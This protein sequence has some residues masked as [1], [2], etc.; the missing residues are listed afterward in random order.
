MRPFV[1]F[2]LLGCL[3][4]LGLT[5]AVAVG[6]A[7]RA[8]HG[9]RCQ[10]TTATTTQP[11]STSTTTTP[12]TTTTPTTGYPASFYSGPAG[13]NILLPPNGTYPADG[14][15]IGEESGNGLTQLQSREQ[16]IGRSFN[17]YSYYAQHR[18]DP[19]PTILGQVVAAG[20]IPMLSWWPTPEHADQIISGQAD[21]CIKAFGDAIANQPA[22]VLVRMYHE[23]NG[24][25]MPF[26]MNSDGTRATASE[27]KQM[28][29][30]TVDVLRTTGFFSRASVVWNVSEG[31]YDNGDAWN[32][33]TPYPGDSYLD[34]VSSDGY[35]GYINGGWCGDHDTHPP[36]TWCP[37][38]D[39]FTHGNH[40]PAYT[41]RGVE[42]D[43]RGR[44]PYM[45]AET[46]S[47]EDPNTPGRKG[48]W[49][50]DMGN[51]AKTY[52][53]GLYAIVYFDLSYNGADWNLDTSTSSLDGFKAFANDSYFNIS[54]GSNP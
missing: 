33:P 21:S 1:R 38:G 24:G 37:F 35:N 30:H 4:L 51:Y 25:W 6:H 28:W 8:C 29:Q 47:V 19:Y 14:A 31:Y 32:N 44:K 40:A 42:A 45:V 53:P 9:H 2:A 27:E 18:C 43:F 22:R 54:D 50:T 5:A 36:P 34:W 46:G 3:G 15:W 12:A 7:G 49:M 13:T 26:S 23:F 39:R 48:Q 41:P 16:Y 11:G 52:M 20:Y 17:I 10:T